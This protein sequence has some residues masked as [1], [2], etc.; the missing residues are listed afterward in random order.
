M[1][2]RNYESPRRHVLLQ[3]ARAHLKREMRTL[4]VR[5]ITPL[6]SEFLDVTRA[7]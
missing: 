4:K 3:Y 5:L 2:E 7:R 1:Y 6:I